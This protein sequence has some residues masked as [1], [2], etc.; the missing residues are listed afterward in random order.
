MVTLAIL[1]ILA[2]AA[3]PYAEM[4]IVRTKELEL[5]RALRDVRA[6]IDSFHEDWKKGEISK[7][8]D[9]VSD[10]G[11]PKSLHVLIEGV[12]AGG[13]EGIKRKY[14]RRIPRDP[15]A[16]DPTQPPEEQWAVRG[17]QDE[18]DSYVWG[19]DDVY[20]IR[21]QSDRTALDGTKYTNW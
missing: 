17:Y 4:T 10:D 18:I 15:F 3:L 20:D 13:L 2:A 19:G 11:Y 8:A 6:S 14:L 9:G 12:E 5:R 21:S 1:A 16:A 7:H